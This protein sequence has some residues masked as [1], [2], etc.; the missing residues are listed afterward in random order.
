[1][2]HYFEHAVTTVWRNVSMWIE[3]MMEVPL[4]NLHVSQACEQH[5]S[6]VEVA[7]SLA[8]EPDSSAV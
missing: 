2:L 1:M 3:L 4:Q 6:A 8:P 7:T 5:R